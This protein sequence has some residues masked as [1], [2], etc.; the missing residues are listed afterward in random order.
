MT[1][2]ET[3]QIVGNQASNNFSE[4]ELQPIRITRENKNG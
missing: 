4:T 1:N 3:L 2:C